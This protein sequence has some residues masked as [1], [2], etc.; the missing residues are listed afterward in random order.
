MPAILPIPSQGT[1]EFVSCTKAVADASLG[2][3]AIIIEAM[4]LMCLRVSQQCIAQKPHPTHTPRGTQHHGLTPAV[5]RNDLLVAL[6]VMLIIFLVIGAIAL[7]TQD[8]RTIDPNRLSEIRTTLCNGT[9]PLL[10]TT[11]SNTGPWGYQAVTDRH[12]STIA[13]RGPNRPA[14]QPLEPSAFILGEDGDRIAMSPVEGMYDPAQLP[15]TLTT[16]PSDVR[17]RAHAITQKADPISFNEIDLEVA[18]P[19]A[20]DPIEQ[21]VPAT[22]NGQTQAQCNQ[23]KSSPVN[24]TSGLRSHT[25]PCFKERLSSITKSLTG[26]TSLRRAKVHILGVGVSWEGNRDGFPA[27]P[28]PPDDIEWLRKMLAHQENFIYTSLIDDKAT[29]VTIRQALDKM[30]SVAEESDFLALYF[31]GHGVEDDSFQLRDLTLLDERV[32]NQWIVELRSKTS[33]RNPVYIVFDFC[34]PGR[35]RPYIELASGV[36]VIWACSPTQSALEVRL[37]SS[38]NDLP[39]S[40]FLMSLILAIDDLSEDSTTSAVGRFTDR[41]KQL[42]KVIRGTACTRGKCRLPWR[43][44]GC[45]ICSRGGH[46]VHDKHEDQLPFQ[47]VSAGGI[48][49]NTDFSIFVEYIASSF[50][51]HIKKVAN[52]VSNNH[53]MLYFNPSYISANRRPFNPRNH[54][55]GL[56]LG[57]DNTVRNMTTPITLMKS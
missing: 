36:K 54:R 29:L 37:G 48:D 39:R 7:A 15:M 47:M 1:S 32:L 46:C 21:Q 56:E 35:V 28:G 14:L 23:S 8:L 12:I 52:Q 43:Y 4:T 41:M 5:Y 40:C 30:L 3:S 51:L 55:L 6:I 50:P 25:T 42:V 2:Q 49:E 57:I 34:R 53:W 22:S 26:L 31:S 27:L 19:Q 10:Q 16:R 38:N 44:C 18:K 11:S 9:V 20:L 17:G 24:Q 45:V 33:K 13:T